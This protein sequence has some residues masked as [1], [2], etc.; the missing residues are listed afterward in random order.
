MPPGPLVCLTFSFGALTVLVP[1]LY[2]IIYFACLCDVVVLK[3]IPVHI[4]NARFTPILLDCINN[5][6][7]FQ[8][9]FP[10]RHL[11]DTTA[12]KISQEI[13]IT[14]THEKNIIFLFERYGNFIEP[15]ELFSK[16]GHVF[17]NF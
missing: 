10:I 2:H 11:T 8:N 17:F 6:L 3:R 15:L 16:S 12:A 7:F 14:G 5:H 9:C 4:L 1:H 13:E